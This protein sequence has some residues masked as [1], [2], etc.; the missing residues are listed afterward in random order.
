M[1]IGL[2]STDWFRFDWKLYL[3]SESCNVNRLVKEMT[4]FDRL[5]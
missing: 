3:E 5:I 2:W 1:S 4:Q